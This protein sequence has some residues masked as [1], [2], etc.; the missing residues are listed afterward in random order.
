LP[1]FLCCWFWCC[2]LLFNVDS[3]KKSHNYSHHSLIDWNILS[4]SIRLML[5]N[6]SWV[7]FKCL[8]F[9]YYCFQEEK[10]AKKGKKIFKKFVVIAVN[11]FVGGSESIEIFFSS[12]SLTLFHCNWSFKRD[13]IINSIHLFLV[14][15]TVED[16]HFFLNFLFNSTNNSTR[17][18][19]C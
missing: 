7:L 19:A 4:H 14:I 8:R 9:C 5:G 15:D 10:I 17:R 3:M 16:S 2:F 11:V 13:L 6:V 12:L 1:F 18:F